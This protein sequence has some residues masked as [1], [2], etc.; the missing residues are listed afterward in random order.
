MDLTKIE[1]Q[2]EILCLYQNQRSITARLERGLFSGYLTTNIEH[3]QATLANS[4]CTTTMA[5]L[6]RLT[7]KLLEGKT[8]SKI[9]TW[10]SQGLY[11]VGVA[12]TIEVLDLHI[13]KPLIPTKL[14]PSLDSSDLPHTIL[15]VE[16]LFANET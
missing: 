9:R 7:R 2:D 10:E 14:V 11:L 16:R 15:K 3:K 13:E 6:G 5:L 1:F 4:Q 8:F 12:S